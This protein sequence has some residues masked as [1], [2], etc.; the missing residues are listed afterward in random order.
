METGIKRFIG[1]KRF[2]RHVMAIAVPIM[3]QNGITNFVSLLDNIM[4]GQIGTEQMSGVA[5]FNQLLF[6][7]FLA[8]F[9]GLSGVGIFTAQYYGQRD[10]EGVRHTFRF[11]LWLG[12]VITVL[13]VLVFLLFGEGLMSLFLDAD[14]SA[15]DAEAALGFGKDYMGIL[16]F[17]M[18][19]MM[20][21]NVYVGTLRD[22]G[23]TTMPMV[24]GVIA[25]LV[26]LVLDYLL[27]FG[28]LG[29]PA[30]GVE[31]AALATVI[32]RYVEMLIVVIRCHTHTK[33]YTY[34][35]HAYK[36]LLVPLNMAKEF[37][38]KG[39]PILIN[40]VCWS[41]GMTFL[42]QCYS[43]RG[44]EVIAAFNIA[45]VM[46]NVLNVVF[47]AMGDAVAI[48]VGQ[49]LGAGKMEEAKRTDTKIIAFAVFAGA[50]V[51]IVMIAASDAFPQI[52]NTSDDVKRIATGIVRIQ[53]LF[54]PQIALLHTS[55]FTLRSGGKTL[56]TFLFDSGFIWAVNVP[57]AFVLSHF[58][59]LD[60][61]WIFAMVQLGEM[62]KCIFGV[63][64]VKKGIWLNTITV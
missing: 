6:V 24:S 54:T 49:L 33:V 30:L 21:T 17:A 40:E 32:A 57:I 16:L 1:N 2:Y 9:G 59:G 7:Y 34:F 60:V 47:F 36:T 27:I 20:F 44:L 50:V 41:V 14:A 25:V 45:N 11:K 63:V 48:I 55:Y 15:G 37:F 56:L 62:L 29:L 38:R 8:L 19:A 35:K 53:A 64:M 18:P 39:I 46:S 43:V 61:L 4:V 31:G 52:Y 58:T 28:K 22:C 51:A 42:M 12:F 5:I 23:R 26:N 3:I 13:A 10:D